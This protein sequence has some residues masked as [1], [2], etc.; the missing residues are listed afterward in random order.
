MHE[1]SCMLV[2]RVRKGIE[3]NI[4]SHLL[5]QCWVIVQNQCCSPLFS[6]T[7]VLYLFLTFCVYI[8][9]LLNSQFSERQYKKIIQSITLLEKKLK[10]TCHI[11]KWLSLTCGSY[12]TCLP[13]DPQLILPAG[14]W[15]IPSTLITSQLLGLHSNGGNNPSDQ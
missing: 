9:G 15:N 11:N 6:L 12:D 7:S 3:E 2:I 5:Y 13:T 4:C 8:F 10:Y 1:I 14:Q